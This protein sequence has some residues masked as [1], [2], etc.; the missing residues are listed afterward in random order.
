[1]TGPWLVVLTAALW[2]TVV[3]AQPAAVD[4]DVVV[5]GGSTAA[6]ATALTAAREGSRTCLVE[7]TDWPGGQLTASG[8]PAIDFAWHR[9]GDLNVGAIARQPE[10]QPPELRRWL[11]LVGNPGK[12]RVSLHC[13]DPRQLLAQAIEPAIRAEPN[14]RVLRNAMVTGVRTALASDGRPEITAVEVVRRRPLRGDGYQQ[15]L[16][17]ALAD[18]Y[19]PQPSA[20]F[21]KEQLLLRS[22]SGRL[23]VVDGSEFGDLLVLAAGAWLQGVERVEGSL[24]SAN[25][26]LGQSFV[27]PFF[28]AIE[29]QPVASGVPLLTPDQPAG[30]STASH[31]WEY[32]WQYRRVLGSGDSAPGQVSNQNWNPGNDYP[33]RYLL[34]SRAAALAQRGRW[35]GGV[36]LASL[37][38]AERQAYGWFRHVAGE[39]PYGASDHYRLAAE[40]A[41]T[42]H[43]LA[44]MPYVRD[45]RRS[46]GIDNYQ[47]VIGDISGTAS[48][49]VA[50]PFADRI[51]IGA[52]DADIHPMAGS[53]PAYVYSHPSVLPYFLPIRALTNRDVANLLVTGKTMAQ[54]FMVNAATRLH[55]IEFSSGIAAGASAA[56]MSANRWHNRQLVAEVAKV[57]ARIRRYAPLEWT[58]GGQRYPAAASPA[59]H[60]CPPG[61]ALNAALGYCEDDSHAYGPFTQA[62]TRKCVQFGGG[63]AC[64]ASG[65]FLI[66]G[67]V[68]EIPRWGRR[69]ASSLRGNGPC[70][71]GSA[72]DSAKGGYCVEEAALSASGRKEVYG[73]FSPELVSRCLANGGG[74]ACYANRWD[75]RFFVA[76]YDSSR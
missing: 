44:K 53:Y 74:D 41:G 76:L 56:L 63:D 61:A 59:S 43:G 54:S 31:G 6:L 33:G 15:R 58:I 22:G 1:M 25:E 65:R 70:M 20:D 28:M 5:A 50:T 23:V 16:S 64:S 60:F 71:E 46:I 34:L 35:R 4:C 9:V 21:S 29:A 13:F 12:C 42:G 67:R 14:L 72:P 62:M 30:Y 8:V 11:A 36:D 69:F 38:A 55:P 17:A 10:N 18:W 40:W 75:Y 39:D 51:A 7:P 37:D 49:L 32:V 47:L 2:S 3:T 73:P 57:Q 52:Y 24:E 66:D 19:D 48:Q 45:T 26:L 27:F 68:V